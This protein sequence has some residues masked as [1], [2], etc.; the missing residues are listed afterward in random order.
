VARKAEADAIEITEE[1]YMEFIEPATTVLNQVK[2]QLY[3]AVTMAEAQADQQKDIDAQKEVMAKN[4]REN[5]LRESINRIRL[6]PV[7]LIGKPVA[8]ISAAIKKLELINPAEDFGDLVNE[9]SDA[10]MTTIVQL[11]AMEKGA[12]ALLDQQAEIDK[13][14]QDQNKLAAAQQK[15][16]D[17][18]A[19][20]DREK[21][22]QETKAAELKARLPEDQKMRAYVTELT[23][24]QAPDVE[25]PEMVAVLRTISVQLADMLEYVFDSTQDPS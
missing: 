19:K 6:A 15:S 14:E 17:D 8:D 22:E 1:V 11:E 4:E 7:D 10:I 24:R 16:V 25:S 2:A 20:E 9:S 3:N 12:Q 18:K 13:R 21:K 23:E 5:K